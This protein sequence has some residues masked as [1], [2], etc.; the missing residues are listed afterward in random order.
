MRTPSGFLK[1]GLPLL[2]L[3][4]GP[5]SY[6]QSASPFATNP[7]AETSAA[8]MARVQQLPHAA[9]IAALRERLQ[10]DA[11][12]TFRNDLSQR[13]G[14]FMSVSAAA[15]VAWDA[16]RRS[17]PDTVVRDSRFLCVVNRQIL[18]G[19]AAAA[20]VADVPPQAIKTIRFL[21]DLSNTV[22]YGDRGAAGVVQVT[23][24]NE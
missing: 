1:Y 24:G 8:W 16:T 15:R 17:A 21:T 9:Q 5:A 14:C 6:A 23:I 3:A 4:A 12:R 2:L 10:A 22:I 7:P 18:T 11:R 20:A 19:L 13:A